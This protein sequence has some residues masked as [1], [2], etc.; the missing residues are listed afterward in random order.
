MDV[1]YDFG[2]YDVFAIRGNTAI[3]KC[4]VPGF[5]QELVSVVAYIRDDNM[6]I[7]TPILSGNRPLIMDYIELYMIA[8]I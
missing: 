2:V 6:K 7:D 3:I 1:D 5:L 4:H 8:E